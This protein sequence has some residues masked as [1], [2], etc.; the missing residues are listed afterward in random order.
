M[1]NKSNKR[2]NVPYYIVGSLATLALLASG[3]FAAAPYV[4][5]LAPIAALGLSA[6][7][8]TVCTA[9]LS[10]VV[11]ALSYNAVSK[12]KAQSTKRVA[13]ISSMKVKLTE[14]NRMLQEE[15]A[16]ELGKAFT[17][18]KKAFSD[19]RALNIV[20]RDILLPS[21]EVA[22]KLGKAFTSTKKAFSDGRALNIVKRD[23]LLPSVEV[24]TELGKAGFTYTKEKL[25]KAYMVFTE[26]GGSLTEK[27]K[28]GEWF[29]PRQVLGIG[30]TFGFAGLLAQYFISPVT[31]ALSLANNS[32]NTANNHN[33]SASSPAN[34]FNPQF[35][36]DDKLNQAKDMLETTKER[37]KKGFDVDPKKHNFVTY[38]APQE[39]TLTQGNKTKSAPPSK[40]DDTA[41]LSKSPTPSL[42]I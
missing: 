32:I 1:A 8:I 18:T 13:L 28:A 33:N 9:F 3:V 31:N 39:S 22:P 25:A 30:A 27:V 7:L 14:I 34:P 40:I 17:S 2:N 19:G 26:I 4:Q 41:D 37:A 35:I 10:A 36:L 42:H 5:F 12:N 29:S 6:P 20:K 38:E 15:V 16:P 23:I 11:I 24:A 21:V